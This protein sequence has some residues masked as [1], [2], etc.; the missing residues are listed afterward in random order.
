MSFSETLKQYK[1]WVAGG[2]LV[3]AALLAFFAFGGGSA[4]EDT[5]SLE[6]V[7][8]GEVEGVITGEG[9][10]VVDENGRVIA[11]SEGGAAGSEAGGSGASG[12][13]GSGAE[14]ANPPITPDP[15]P[16]P[17]PPAPEGA[18]MDVV[19]LFW[20]DTADAAPE[21][22]VVSLAG[23]SYAPDTGGESDSG[24]LEGLAYDTELEL[25]I[26]PD[27]PGGARFAVPVMFTS[28]MEPGS[29]R[30]AIHVEISDA[31]VRVIGNA[32]ENFDHRF[33]RF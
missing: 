16:D 14:D 15:V 8:E 32:V 25:V 1:W 6:G 9:A 29:E 27:G 21:G 23:E 19:I 22:A 20:N 33:D 30:D 12:S 5:A 2:V 26:E 11:V 7:P 28:V 24:T 17:P 18:V 31:Q 4:D 10:L 13:E 3:I